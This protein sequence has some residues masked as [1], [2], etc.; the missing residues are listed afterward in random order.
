MEDVWRLE[1]LT[2]FRVKAMVTDS[3]LQPDGFEF[4]TYSMNQRDFHTL[5]HRIG[6]DPSLLRKWLADWYDRERTRPAPFPKP[7]P[8]EIVDIQMR[9]R[10]VEGADF[11]AKV[12]RGHYL[13]CGEEMSTGVLPEAVA[14]WPRPAVLSAE[15]QP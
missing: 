7:H 9:N 14:V 11:V 2:Y 5:A 3:H 6:E 12:Q 15:N 4:V 1:G 10:G 8:S 13:L